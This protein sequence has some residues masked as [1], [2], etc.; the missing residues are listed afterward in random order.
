MPGALDAQQ[1]RARGERGRGLA[2]R[3]QRR[4][5]DRDGLGRVERGGA[6][7]GDD[8]GD[9]LAGVADLAGRQHRVRRIG[10]LG[11]VA[12]AESEA[13]IAHQRRN[14]A[15]A[16][17]R[18]IVGGEDAKHPRHGQGAGR[19]E[20]PQTGMGV[21]RAHHGHMGLA[22]QV[23]VVGETAAPGQQARVLGAAHRLADAE[24][25]DRASLSRRRRAPRK[26]RNIPRV[27]GMPTGVRLVGRSH[28]DLNIIRTAAGVR[29]R[30]SPQRA[31]QRLRVLQIGDVEAFRKPDAGR[32]PPVT[33]RRR[34]VRTARRW[35]AASRRGR[36]GYRS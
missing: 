34:G 22:G 31:E 4:V 11:A 1:R 28:G 16:V 15:D 19:L 14:T 27:N 32:G 10:H 29:V 3:G 33:R 35:S 7:L 2:D 5:V 12:V 18:Q 24:I 23:D 26:D 30:R 36:G 17:G 21:G 8:D 6:R 13:R 20:R 25:H 9:R